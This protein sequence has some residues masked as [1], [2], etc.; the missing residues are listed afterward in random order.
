MA[1]MVFILFMLLLLQPEIL[2]DLL[3]GKTMDEIW[4]ARGKTKITAGVGAGNPNPPSE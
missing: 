1:F 3:A 4:A 2:K